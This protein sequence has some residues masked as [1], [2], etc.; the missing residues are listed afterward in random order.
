MEL[1]RSQRLSKSLLWGLQER[2]YRDY[3]TAVWSEKGV[4]FYL[5]SNPLTAKQFS[6]LLLGYLRDCA[7]DMQPGELSDGEPFYLFDLG[8]GTG[9]LGWLIL[10]HLLPMVESCFSGK[11]RICYV[12]TDMVEANI[13]YWQE[14]PS[15]APYV[16]SGHLDFAL[17]HH[18][19]TGPL[20]LVNSKK[21][22]QRLQKPAALICTYYFDT[23]PQD[24]FR[25]REGE[26]DEGQVSLTAS[27]GVV[28]P[29]TIPQMRADFSYHPIHEPTSYYPDR[30]EY[31]DLLMRYAR[32]YSC[33]PFTFPL[34]GMESLRYFS[35]LCDER[36]LLLSA[37]Q[38]A[39]TKEQMQALNGPKIS[40][41]ASFSITVDYYLLK[42]YFQSK[43]GIGFTTAFSDPKF[44][45][46][47]GVLGRDEKR[48][49]NTQLAF[50][51]GID[52]F[53][54]VD[55]LEV[56]DLSCEM[57]EKLT[58]KQ[59]LLLIKLGNWD[60]MNVNFFYPE[61]LSKCE[62]A[63]DRERVLLRQ[64]IY[65]VLDY[66]YPVSSAEGDF[67][68][69]LGVLLYQMGL[70]RDAQNVFERALEV[71]SNTSQLQQYIAACDKSR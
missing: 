50:R 68:A 30:P 26:L 51:A 56:T 46:F 49:A 17:Y 14:H 7:S 57:R 69:N 40:W 36:L 2:V 66:T 71:S 25:A 3:S 29:S 19:H 38:G 28:D 23:L 62:Q 31:N 5:T 45:V 21:V 42:Q 24:L 4:P 13:T 41:H 10:K 33:T 11:V 34:G 15:L 65:R 27:S 54:P 63:S 70:Y 53:E 58:L 1:E 12:M 16:Q 48:V 59:L 6:E 20:Q 47:A 64:T 35:S 8:A 9:R 55:Y 43:G 32:E 52:A 67:M 22:L 44:V 39:T 37:D 18:T 61:L 60:P